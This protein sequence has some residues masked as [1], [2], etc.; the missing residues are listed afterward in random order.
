MEKSVSGLS[1]QVSTVHD[2]HDKAQLCFGLEGVGQ[3]DN[4]P[5]V[6]SSQDPLLHHGA[7]QN[8]EMKYLRK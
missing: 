8:R 4:E 5:A 3:G 1:P 7:L 2:G 6:N